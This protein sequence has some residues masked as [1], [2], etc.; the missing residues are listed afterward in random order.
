MK[1]YFLNDTPSTG[2]CFIAEQ[3]RFDM[4]YITT[5]SSGKPVVRW[6][7]GAFRAMRQ[8]RR[9]DVVICWYDFQALILFFLSAVTFGRRHVVA[10]NILLKEKDGF[11]N[12]LVKKLY[13]RAFRSPFFRCTITSE[14][15]GDWLSSQF[16][17]CHK[18]VLLHD[19]YWDDDDWH[20]DSEDDYVFCGGNNG[21]D[22]KFVFDLA[23]M[24]PDV[25][26][27]IIAPVAV[28]NEFGG[29]NLPNVTLE[30][31][32]AYGEFIRVLSRSVM[33]LLP[34]DTEAPAGLMVLFQ[35]GANARFVLA[36][37]TRTSREYVREGFGE[38]LPPDVTLWAER[39][40]FWL[41]HP[42]QRRECGLRLK[43]F[44]SSECTKSYFVRTIDSIVERIVTVE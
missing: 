6:F 24:L 34:L 2:H 36:T 41:S 15:Y 9:G 7:V 32:V 12:R 44:I 27:R 25:P 8:S 4:E 13:A 31:N 20:Q 30:S 33:T 39:I 10:L 29:G 17:M 19:L 37:S 40:R 1:I 18:P 23:A 43:T 38:V 11:R 42:E 21:R 14:E 5:P 16:R 22:W 3:S 28:C 26:F 35:S